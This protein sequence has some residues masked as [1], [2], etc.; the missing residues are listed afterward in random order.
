MNLDQS[1][2]KIKK[3]HTLGPTGTNCEAA[4]Y[5][6]FERNELSG[7]VVLHPT[8]EEAVEQIKTDNDGESGLLSC[9]V[10]PYLHTLVFGNRDRLYLLDS[11]IMPTFN[12]IL[13]SKTGKAPVVVATHP[14]PQSLAPSG[15]QRVL[16]NSNSEAA[17]QCANGEVDGCITTMVAAK[18]NNLVVVTDYG[19]IPMGFAVHAQY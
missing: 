6:W 19:T 17:I 2:S 10:Y 7:E 11:F 13:A 8:L 3:L 18:A 5:N 9:I 1:K 4:A 16:V 14:A 15:C 12:M